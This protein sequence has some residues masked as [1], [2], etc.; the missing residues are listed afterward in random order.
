MV[1]TLKNYTFLPWLRAGIGA[2]IAQE[3]NLG[4]PGAAPERASV[5]VEF[6]IGPEP[7]SKTAHLL[8]PRDVIG[9]NSRAIVKT[10]PRD[11]ITDFEANYLPYIEFYEED[12]PWRFTA[13]KAVANDERLRPWIFLIVLT[14]DEF[15][16]KGQVGPLPAFEIKAGVDPLQVFPRHDETWAWAH[17]HIGRNVIGDTLLRTENATHVR[18]FEEKLEDLL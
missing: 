13:A 6:T 7:V 10:E 8:G 1:A 9:I 5:Q 2:E 12:F 14:E 4:I 3:D 11:G 18:G 16:E 17:V 15:D